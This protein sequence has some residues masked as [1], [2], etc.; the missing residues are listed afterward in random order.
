MNDSGDSNE[1]GDWAIIG[2]AGHIYADGSGFLLY[3][4]TDESPRRWGFLK[5]AAFILPRDAG[6]RRRGLLA[7]RPSPDAGSEAGLIRQ[8][9]GIRKRRHLSPDAKAQARVA[10]ERARSHDK[11]P[12][13][14]PAHSPKSVEG[15]R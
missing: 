13:Q 7:P 10:L 11:T 3:V 5:K 2:K 8:A 15:Y 9:I 14:P 6:R 1:R 12:H 4:A